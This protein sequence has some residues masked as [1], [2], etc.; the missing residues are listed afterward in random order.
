MNN[1]IISVPKLRNLLGPSKC[2]GKY[3]KVLTRMFFLKQL[4]EWVTT[5]QPNERTRS[6]SHELPI[7]KKSSSQIKIYDVTLYIP[8]VVSY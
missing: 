4:E 7:P 1:V 5:V 3:D 2:A 8:A 6:F